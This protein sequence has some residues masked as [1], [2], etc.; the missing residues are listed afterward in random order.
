VEDEK[1]KG[2]KKPPGLCRRFLEFGA[3]FF[4][5]ALVSPPGVGENQK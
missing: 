3:F 5:Y 2:K 4:D 1:T